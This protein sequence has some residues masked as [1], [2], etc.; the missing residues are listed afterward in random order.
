MNFYIIVVL[1]S[2]LKAKGSYGD[3]KISLNGSEVKP[4]SNCDTV[5]LK[6]K[7]FNKATQITFHRQP[8]V[9]KNEKID[10]KRL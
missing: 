5:T 9:F 2:S 7:I 3:L 8:F 10:K 4:M 6:P 1:V